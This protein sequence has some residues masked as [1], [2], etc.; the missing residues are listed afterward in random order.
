MARRISLT[1]EV[2]DRILQQVKAG[3]P[4]KTAALVAGVSEETFYRW[5]R[6][7]E[8]SE[9]PPK[10]SDTLFE[11]CQQFR[12]RL[13]EAQA[14]AHALFVSRLAKASVGGDWLEEERI[15]TK[16]D[17]SVERVVTRKQ[18]PPNANATMFMLERRFPD[19]WGRR[20]I[21]AGDD[22]EAPMIGKLVVE[23]PQMQ[24]AMRELRD[25]IASK[26]PVGAA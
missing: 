6:I 11:R 17:G 15:V 18:L 13:R 19:E 20:A 25:R 21:T 9:P 22:E 8:S 26:G 24:A 12:Q 1:D 16:A 7:G 14:T 4:N 10:T 5:I 2:E 23:D 3:V